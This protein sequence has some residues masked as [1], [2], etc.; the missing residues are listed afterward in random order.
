[1]DLISKIAIKISCN[2]VG[3]DEFGNKY[4]E[5]KNPTNGRK[6]RCV[7]Y[8]GMAEPSKVPPEWHGWLHYTSDEIPKITHRNSWQKTHLPNLTGTKFAYFPS[9]S[10]YGK[11]N[12]NKVSS[13]YQPW[14]PN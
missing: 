13:D 3:I 5:A 14:Q 9:G 8:K 1:M 6:K 2:Q 11:D 4:F 12:R 10:K 7:I